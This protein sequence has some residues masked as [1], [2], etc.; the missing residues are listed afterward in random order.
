LLPIRTNGVLFDP[1]AI[2]RKDLSSELV[3]LVVD[4]Q[5]NPAILLNLVHLEG[6]LLNLE[7]ILLNFQLN[8]KHRM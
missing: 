3:S 4:R 8:L 6:I 7:G 2:E 5:V 1:M